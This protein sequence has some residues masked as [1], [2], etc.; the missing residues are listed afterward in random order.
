MEPEITETIHQLDET[1]INTI[2]GKS[3]SK[4]LVRRPRV[5]EQPVIASLVHLTIVEMGSFL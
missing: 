3:Y 4:F 2:P 5:V 1:V